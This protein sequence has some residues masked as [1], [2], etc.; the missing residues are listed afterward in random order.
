VAGYGCSEHYPDQVLPT[1]AGTTAPP[2]TTDAGNGLEATP[3]AEIAPVNR[4]DSASSIIVYDSPRSGVWVANADVGT[5]TF[6]DLSAADAGAPASDA[7]D[8][9]V[10]ALSPVSGG[11]GTVEIA[12]GSGGATVSSVALSPDGAWVAAVDRKGAQVALIDATTRTVRRTLPLGTRPRAAVWDA[13]NPRYLY[14]SQEDDDAVTVVDRTAGAVVA[15]VPAGE[16]PS[17]LAVSRLRH[18]LTVLHRGDGALLTIDLSGVAASSFPATVPADSGP[19]TLDAGT[20]ELDLALEPVNDDP[21]QPQ[22]APFGVESLA[23]L[24]DGITAWIPHE[25]LTLRQPFQFQETL[26][27]TVSVVDLSQQAEVV[28]DPNDPNSVVA[29]RKL[30]FGAIDLLDAMGNT[31]IMSQPCAAVMN[32]RG[33]AGYVLACASEDLL[34]FDTFAGDAV[35][36]LRGLPGDHPAGIA[37]DP[38]GARGYVY[39]DQSH[40]VTVLDLA[41]GNPLAHVSVVGA[42]IATVTSDPVAPALRQGETLFFR[43]NSAKGTLAETGNNWLSCGGCHLDGFESGN[44]AFFQLLVPPDAGANAQIGHEG[45]ADGFASSSTPDAGFDPHDILVALSDQG[46]LAPDRT[47]ADRTGAVDPAQPTPDAIALA[48]SLAQVVARDLPHGSSWLVNDGAPPNTTNDVTFCGNCHPSEYQA[49]SKSAHAH[50]AADPMVRFCSNLE[51]QTNGPATQRHCAGCHDPVSLRTGDA[52]LQSG[53]SVTCLGCHENV[54]TIRAGG[55]ADLEAVTYDWTQDHR[56]RAAADL[57]L[58]RKPQFCGGCHEQFTPGTA[59]S[60]ITTYEEWQGSAFG[61][62]A[63]PVACVDCHMPS[64][65]TGTPT[66]FDHGFVGGNVY[67]ATAFADADFVAET[68]AKLQSAMSVSAT[69]SGAS[70]AVTVQNHG[71]GHA[72]PTGVTDIREPWV[73]LDAVDATGTVLAR[74]GGP[75]ASGLLPPTAAR[76]G[77]DIAD[78]SGDVLLLHQLSATTRI[79]FDRRIPAGGSVT[80]TLAAPDSLPAGAT[81]LVATLYYHNVRTTFYRAASGDP[82]GSA[83]AVTVASAPVPAN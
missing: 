60:T 47:G 78:A 81:G 67:L 82:T 66:V 32:P 76:F 40:T 6:V 56:V 50:A 57:T 31:E 61:N 44:R 5:V 24:P 15:T 34:T 48:Q 3:P 38:T 65:G 69:R 29:G 51:G 25:L 20:Q 75:D 14:I 77:I 43:A 39:A 33:S 21:T 52:T 8:A 64:T 2:P 18:Q 7:G 1:E 16:K 62:P 72:F 74:Y 35:D 28:T 42:P 30:L 58:L 13:W 12:I 70:V 49:W 71:A 37:V 55:N 27:P 63:S 83:P 4:L 68:T 17:G 41:G 80:V 26:F 73:E 22:G 23:W 9:A 45:L 54:R 19:A 46:G 59:V 11:P 53:R 79:P 36:I 10:T